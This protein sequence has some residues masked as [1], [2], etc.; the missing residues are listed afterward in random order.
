MIDRTPRAHCLTGLPGQRTKALANDRRRFVGGGH[1][2]SSDGRRPGTR[3]ILGA[4][5]ASLSGTYTNA[6][7]F[8]ARRRASSA[9]TW[10]S[11]TTRPSIGRRSITW[12]ASPCSCTDAETQPPRVGSIPPCQRVMLATGS[13]RAK[14]E[15]T[16]N[17]L[18]TETAPPCASA[19]A[20]AIDKPRPVPPTMRRSDESPW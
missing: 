9:S 14:I 11:P 16:P 17:S 1:E 19:M 13:S 5:G 15:P 7:T 2:R 3:G 10:T 6:L 8:G 12:A 20:F 4:Y 18:C